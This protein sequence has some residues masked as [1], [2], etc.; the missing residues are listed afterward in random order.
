MPKLHN[1][2]DSHWITAH[3][4]S[5]D[6]TIIAIT[7]ITNLIPA[8]ITIIFTVSMLIMTIMTTINIS[9]PTNG[10]LGGL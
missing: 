7:D 9:H 5:A 1:A 3:L 4:Y 10:S 6:L 2:H 8:T